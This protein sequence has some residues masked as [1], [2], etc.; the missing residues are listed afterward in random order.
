MEQFKAQ[1]VDFP[2]AF[3][4]A[5]AAHQGTPITSF[6]RGFDRFKDVK[7]VEPSLA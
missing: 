1:P 7:R 4:A 5:I 2:D 6:D 3:V